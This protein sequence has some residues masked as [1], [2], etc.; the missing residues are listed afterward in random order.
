[1]LTPHTPRTSDGRDPT[2]PAASAVDGPK[3]VEGMDGG[4]LVAKVERCRLTTLVELG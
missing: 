2:A 1:M 4:E 3:A